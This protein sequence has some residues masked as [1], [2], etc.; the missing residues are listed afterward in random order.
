MSA[1]KVVDKV[2]NGADVSLSLPLSH[3]PTNTRYLPYRWPYGGFGNEEVFE[4]A[5]LANGKP[6]PTALS[7]GLPCRSGVSV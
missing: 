7:G 3:P 6:C 2:E 4:D 5:R 1:E